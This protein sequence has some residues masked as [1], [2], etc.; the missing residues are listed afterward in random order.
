MMTLLIPV[1]AYVGA[2]HDLTPRQERVIWSWAYRICGPDGTV[3]MD[4]VPDRRG[5]YHLQ[6]HCNR[7][8]WNGRAYPKAAR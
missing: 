3:D 4:P 1:A 2:N 6:P 5:R 8:G 7:D